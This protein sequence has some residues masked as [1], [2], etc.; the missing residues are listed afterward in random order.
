[1]CC[2]R[3]DPASCT[4]SPTGFPNEGL[5]EFDSDLA[6]VLRSNVVRV[7]FS[8]IA[9]ST[10]ILFKD[11]AGK[12]VG[13]EPTAAREAIRRIG[14][15]YGRELTVEFVEI[16]NAAFFPP[17][18]AA[19]ARR[20][21]DL[22][23]SRIGVNDARAK[24]VDFACQEFAS[25]IALASANTA[26]T[27]FAEFTTLGAG[28]QAGTPIRVGCVQSSIFC[29]QTLPTGFVFFQVADIAALINGFRAGTPAYDFMI[30]NGEQIT[31]D[32]AQNS[33]QRPAQNIHT[34]STIALAPATRR[35]ERP[36]LA[37]AIA[38]VATAHANDIS[39]NVFGKSLSRK[40]AEAF[41][42]H[43]RVAEARYKS[44]CASTSRRDTCTRVVEHAFKKISDVFSEESVSDG[45]S[46]ITSDL[47]D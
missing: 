5:I 38:S 9:L 1:L 8:S 34:F 40:S 16:V 30:L 33:Y 17:Q 4:V 3:V 19:L 45:L 26:V 12:L 43:A 39:N 44:E 23:W 2:V 7:G 28:A 20:S 11:T 27:S 22:L 46:E 37:S 41:A 36:I 42:A 18:A 29:S 35:L 47:S 15:H 6:F 13:Y 32:I 25:T 31:F 24:D 10:P 21:V 14:A